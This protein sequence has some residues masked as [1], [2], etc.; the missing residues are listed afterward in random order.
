MATVAS[1]S[2]ASS[3]Y[4]AYNYYSI[5]EGLGHSEWAGAAAAELGLSG[6]V[7]AEMF[8]R[9][10]AG[11]LP[12]GEVLSGGAKDH[13]PGF[14]LTFSAPKS[15]S[16]LALV[17]GDKRL[18]AAHH[19]AVK[20]TM[21][22]V[23]T[24]LAEGRAGKDGR[25][26]VPTGKLAYALFTHDVSRELDPQLHTHSVIANATQRPDG[27]WRALHNGSI[28][29][30]N[31]LIGAIYHNELRHGVTALGYGIAN[32][33]KNGTFEIEGISRQTIE[34]WSARHR[35]IRA[36]AERLGVTSPEGLS[37]IAARSREAKPVA[38]PASLRD[39][40]RT[41]AAARGEDFRALIPE[42]QQAHTESG[43][44]GRLRAWGEAL[45]ARATPFFRPRPEALTQDSE[46]MRRTAA[47]GA[48]YAVGAAVRHL[49]ERDASFAEHRVLQHALNFAE[50]KARIGDVEQRLATLKGDGRLI[51]GKA[52]HA[53]LLTTPEMLLVE[54]Q[55]VALARAGI[56]QASAPLPID[57]AASLVG[58][59]AEAK[60][61]FALSHEQMQAATA[62][63]AG[64]DRFLTIQGGAGT[65]KSTVF[66]AVQAVARETRD[67]LFI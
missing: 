28:W 40:W 57:R 58:Q 49:E 22:W 45:L 17:G 54:R 3:Y 14:D 8:E 42:Q 44:L 55:I 18:V 5:D 24:N 41:L 48:T 6:P 43:V 35:Q 9:V 31:M 29:R 50:Q 66:A 53:A 67:P 11:E 32:G 25:E 27:A 62:I 7:D 30:A 61:G 13:A 20:S 47:I 52:E 12:N 39:E 37:A 38:D 1:A 26:V 15:V 63:L 65:G 51:A 60:L 21:G 46:A 59:A 2:S 23:E 34:A 19:A 4:A 16:L 10:L 64:T 56:G 33:G 36:I